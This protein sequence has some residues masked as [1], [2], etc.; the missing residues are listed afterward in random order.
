MATA[1]AMTRRTMTQAM[2]L[3]KCRSSTTTT[4]ARDCRA[5]ARLRCAARAAE[6]ASPTRHTVI[7]SKVCPHIT[8]F[9]VSLFSPPNAPRQSNYPLAFGLL[10]SL[11]QCRTHTNLT[12]VLRRAAHDARRRAHAACKRQLRTTIPHTHTHTHTHGSSS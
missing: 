9:A 10:P 3:T 4:M 5:R 12:R 11:P 1:M 6:R 7:L 2:L 8:K